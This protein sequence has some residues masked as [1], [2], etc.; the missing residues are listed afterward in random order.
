MIYLDGDCEEIGGFDTDTDLTYCERIYNE[1]TDRFEGTVCPVCGSYNVVRIDI[2]DDGD[3]IY[4]R[5]VCRNCGSE[6]THSFWVHS[7]LITKD[8]RFNKED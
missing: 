3:T 4:H 1:E 8:G 5:C 2:V 6:F 7:T